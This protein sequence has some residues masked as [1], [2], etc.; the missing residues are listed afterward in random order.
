MKTLKKKIKML[1]EKTETGFSAYSNEYPVFTTGVSFTE[2]LQNAVEATNLFLSDQES[3]ITE[4]SI[5]FEID[6][7]Q[8][9]QFYRVINSKFLA[10]RIGMNETLLSQYVQGRK[11]PSAAQTNKILHGIQE[12]GRE[13]SNINLF[14]H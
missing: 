10:K 11:K 2:L 12:I 1:V 3:R 8:F 4:K 6:L 14:S 7:Q 5:E 13:L 9:F